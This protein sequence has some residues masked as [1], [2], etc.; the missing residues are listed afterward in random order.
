V[1]R[2]VEP[3]V[4]VR[5]GIRG[6]AAGVAAHGRCATGRQMW[7]AVTHVQ[8]TDSAAVGESPVRN[9][10]Q[11]MPSSS[12]SAFSSSVLSHTAWIANDAW[13]VS[14]VPSARRMTSL[15]KSA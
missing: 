13:V 15:V 12:R 14:S 8:I 1:F 5:A 6:D 2:W 3:R 11:L 9:A 7:K 4:R 10:G